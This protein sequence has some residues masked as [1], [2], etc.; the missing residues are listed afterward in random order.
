MELDR[1]LHHDPKLSS[2]QHKKQRGRP[3]AKPQEEPTANQEMEGRAV[4]AP[5]T[6]KVQVG[7]QDRVNEAERS[8]SQP[9]QLEFREVP[10][11]RARK[12]AAGKD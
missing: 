3:K 10:K 11:P 8:S 7:S 12:V 6:Q 2:D 5:L 9:L 1:I 4:L